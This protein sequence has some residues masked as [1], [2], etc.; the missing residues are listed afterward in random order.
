MA[1]LNAKEYTSFESI[2]HIAEDSSEF[3]LARELATVL[4]ILNGEILLK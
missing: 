4:N 2:K 3:W 1:N